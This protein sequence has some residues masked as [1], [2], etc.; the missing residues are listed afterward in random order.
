MP[1]VA[2]QSFNFFHNRCSY[3]IQCAALLK[4]SPVKVTSYII[5]AKYMK[6]GNIVP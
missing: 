1:Y 4:V 3:S 6:M 5:V 2:S